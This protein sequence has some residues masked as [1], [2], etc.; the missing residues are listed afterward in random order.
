MTPNSSL[1]SWIISFLV[2]FAIIW[3][4]IPPSYDEDLAQ[5]VKKLRKTNIFF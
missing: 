5:S 2:K 4:E 3:G 1:I